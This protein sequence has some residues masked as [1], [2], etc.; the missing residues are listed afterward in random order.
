[1]FTND[2][3][4]V[5]FTNSTP[6]VLTP[7]EWFLSAVNISGVPVTYSIK[8]TEWPAGQVADLAIID[9]SFNNNEFCIT[10]ASV[11]GGHYYVTGKPDLLVTNWTTLTPT[12]T[13]V[14]YTTTWCNPLPSPYHFF[15]VGEGLVL[16]TYAPPP[17]IQSPVLGTNSVTLR[18]NG[19]TTA[20]YN[21]QWTPA[22]APPVWTSFTNVITSVTG[23]FEFTDDG[24]QTAG[25]DPLRFYR[26]IQLP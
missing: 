1:V 7:G 16:S 18:W 15:R 8:A 19:P 21:V 4:I 10:W 22:L 13:A 26:L 11:P 9:Y 12:I 17:R 6:V 25:L 23:L 24:T 2:E 20:A 5:V 14:D 3:L